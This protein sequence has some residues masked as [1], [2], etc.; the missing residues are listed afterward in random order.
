LIAAHHFDISF[1]IFLVLALV[2]AWLVVRMRPTPYIPEPG[3]SGIMSRLRS[4]FEHARERRPTLPALV[5]VA[6]MSLF[7]VSHMALIPI[8]AEKVLGDLNTFSWIVVSTGL[9]AVCGALATGFSRRSPSLRRSAGN[10]LA[11]GLTLVLFAQATTTPMA[12]LTQFGVGYFY[13]AV[14]TSLQ[15]LIQQRVDE[16]RRGRVM[17]LFQVCWAG[18]IPFG[19]LGMGALCALVGIVTTLSASG[20]ACAAYALGV[21][22]LSGRLEPRAGTQRFDASGLTA[23]TSPPHATVPPPPIAASR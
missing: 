5:T 22:V 17:S 11:Y 12:L 19:G 2:S 13:F 18:L 8:Y 10:M 7:G 4:G 3:E 15:T 9:G 21:L 23:A 6:S 1:A 16:S 20:I 14:M